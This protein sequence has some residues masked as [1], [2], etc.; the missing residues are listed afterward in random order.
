M[1]RRLIF[2]S[3]F[4][5]DELSL[6]FVRTSEYTTMSYAP[7]KHRSLFGHP[8]ERAFVHRIIRVRP[9]LLSRNQR[10]SSD[11]ITLQS[12]MNPVLRTYLLRPSRSPP[13]ATLLLTAPVNLLCATSLYLFALLTLRLPQS[14]CYRSISTGSS[15]FDLPQATFI[16]RQIREDYK[17]FETVLSSHTSTL[18]ST[19]QS[20]CA[21]QSRVKTN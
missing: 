17:A 19:S 16:P 2:A 3:L 21:I 7:M 12:P 6:L 8:W 11:D 5:V 14:Q 15:R 1:V 4:Y 10:S 20:I 18:R 13:P 9:L